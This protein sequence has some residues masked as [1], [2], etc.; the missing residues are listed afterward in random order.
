[1]EV[2]TQPAGSWPQRAGSRGPGR[3]RAAGQLKP[4]QRLRAAER[5]EKAQAAASIALGAAS[6]YLEAEMELPAFFGHLA[7]TVAGLVGARRVAFWR[8]APKGVLVL[9]REPFGFPAQAPIRALRIPIAPDGTS[10]VERIVFRD[11]LDIYD[12]TS[13]A[14]DHFWREH[15]LSGHRNSIAVSWAAGDQRIGALA[16]YDSKRG[17]TTDDAWVL[18]VAAMATGLVWQYREA[19]EELDVAVERLEE[20]MAARRQLLANVAAGGDEARRRFASALHDDS[21]QLLTAAE[22]QLERIRN[23]STESRQSAKLAELGATIKKVEDSLRRLLSTVSPQALDLTVGLKEAIRDRLESLRLHAGIEPDIDLRIPDD[24][25]EGV[26]SIVF[27]NV[28][29]ALINV[30]K[31][32]HAAR[33][34][35][36]ASSLDGGVVVEVA[37]DGTGFVVDECIYVPGHLGLLAMKER[38]QLAGGWCRIESEPGQGAK[39]E[40]WVPTT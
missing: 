40:F 36:T 37:D 21:L 26:E 8:L 15:G 32:A 2:A 38:A 30:E 20:A 7:E 33:V 17:F 6:S 3:L 31:H 5:L 18:R 13:P 29:E 16:A 12:G 11:E 19:E 9:Q 23:E 14:L 39:I 1:V 22:L 34:R 28:A 25:P 4:R 24:I 10:V 27:K 35:V